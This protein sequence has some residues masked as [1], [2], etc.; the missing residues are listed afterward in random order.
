MKV[1]SGNFK[2]GFFALSA[3]GILAS[4]QD[5]SA[6]ELDWSGQFRSE[7][8]YVR[9]YTL[10]GRS[11]S[12][13]PD[14]TRL[15]Q[16]YYIPG[17]GD[18]SAHFQT[19][20]MRLRPKLVVN[21][22]IYVKSELWFGDPIFGFFGGSAPYTVD[23]RQYYSTQLR[24]STVTAQRYWAE[25]LSDIGTVQV[26]R[27]P[28]HW[29]L[30]LFWNNGEGIWDRYV[31]SADVIRL[32]SKFGAFTVTPGI[33][34]Y[35]QGN[36][37]GGACDFNPATGGCTPVLGTGVVSDYSL[38]FKYENADEDLEGGVNF[39][40]RLAGASQDP[41]SGY[42]GVGATGAGQIPAGMN[43]VV[44]DLYGRKNFGR[45]SFG[46]EAPIT[47]GNVGGVNY[48][49]FAV[50]TETEWKITDNWFT[51]L[52]AGHAPGQPDTAGA[53]PSKYQ[54]F[55][56]NP[57]YKLGLIMFNY[58][59][60]NF[61][62]PNNQN[63]PGTG[64]NGLLSPYDNSIVNANYLSLGAGYQTD[65]W[66]FRGNFIYARANESA[67]AT[68]NYFNT[69]RRTF[70][71]NTTGVAQAT[72]LG[73]EM[74]YGVGFKWDEAFQVN[75]DA[76][77]FFPGDFYKFSNTATPNATDSVFATVVRAGVNF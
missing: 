65:K 9:N 64:A 29:G 67:S 14:A 52:R 8:H 18:T 34:K 15:G 37:I 10:D 24:G 61:A 12:A 25:L 66:I 44:W 59:L 38:S 39:V 45:F 53:L 63:N 73:W 48:K 31:S 57:N 54:A 35:S 28:Q 30:G 62:G 7:A 47:D 13:T 74:D 58:Q 32:V 22:N 49:T 17:G 36:N 4:A 60:A 26:G 72:D 5:G 33:A 2:L 3:V 27:A 56:F 40:K 50:A 16:G 42:L 23:Q 43:Y 69:W 20:F 71:T 6:L 68:G 55:Y 41:S 46:V 51:N 76:G 70:E 77:W 19:L 75:V 11:A 21:D 1:A